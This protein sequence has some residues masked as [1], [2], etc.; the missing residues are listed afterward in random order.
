M[1]MIANIIAPGIK[2]IVTNSND[3]KFEKLDRFGIIMIPFSTMSNFNTKKTAIEA[4]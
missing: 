1:C 4:K 3:L 2:F